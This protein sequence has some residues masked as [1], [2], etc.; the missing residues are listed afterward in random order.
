MIGTGGG[1]VLV[2]MARVASRAQGSVLPAGVALRARRSSM[3]T[4]ER[5][6]GF[7]VI[8]SRA[9]PVGGR[10]AQRTILWKSGGGVIRIVSALVILQVAGTASG[11]ESFVNSTRMALDTSRRYMLA[12]ERERCLRCVIKR[13]SGPVGRSVAELAILRETGC[14]VIRII[15][16]LVV[17]QVA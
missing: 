8:E 1:I 13:S 12:G 14:R 16:A 10:V 9:Q 4:G 6:L 7:A 2:R 17:G 11:T 15:C 3:F 5:E